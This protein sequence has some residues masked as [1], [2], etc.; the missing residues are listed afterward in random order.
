MYLTVCSAFS[1]GFPSKTLS[2]V[3]CSDFLDS[4]S[5]ALT[6]PTPRVEKF[7]VLDNIQVQ[8]SVQ[9]LCTE[10]QSTEFIQDSLFFH[11]SW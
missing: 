5:C 11:R 6:N 8:N 3:L 4:W 10:I 7:Q 1:L 9:I 2:N